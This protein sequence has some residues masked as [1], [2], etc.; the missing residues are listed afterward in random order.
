MPVR[1]YT[2]ENGTYRSRKESY[3]TDTRS[4]CQHS[5]QPSIVRCCDCADV[6]I[7]SFL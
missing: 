7:Q 6:D 1:V 2:T 3:N 4:L 5:L